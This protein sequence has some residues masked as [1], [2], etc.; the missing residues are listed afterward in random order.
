MIARILTEIA[1][2]HS[3]YQVER[4]KHA[5][6][7]FERR[8]TTSSVNKERRDGAS[9]VSLMLRRIALVAPFKGVVVAFTIGK[10]KECH[11]SGDCM[12]V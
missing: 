7:R 1:G 3:T 10:K 9:S 11:P 5:F 4:S 6:R 12:I 2:I 8:L